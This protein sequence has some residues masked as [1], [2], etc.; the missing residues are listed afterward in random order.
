MNIFSFSI[1]AR[2]QYAHVKLVKNGKLV[3]RVNLIDD[4]DQSSQTVV[5][6]LIRGDDIAVPNDDIAAINFNGE[7]YTTFSGFLLYDYSDGAPIVGKYL[8]CSDLTY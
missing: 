4:W 7:Y 1:I 3:A 8:K 5:F 2:G 6:Q